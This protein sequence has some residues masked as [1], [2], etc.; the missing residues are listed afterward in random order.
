MRSEPLMIVVTVVAV[1]VAVLLELAHQ[2]GAE[3]ERALDL[4]EHVEAD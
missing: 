3:M 4:P 2:Q 1:A